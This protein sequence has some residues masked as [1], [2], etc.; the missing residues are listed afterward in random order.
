[1]RVGQQF[2]A[3]T[4]RAVSRALGANTSWMPLRCLSVRLQEGCSLLL[5][6]PVGGCAHP[7]PGNRAMCHHYMDA[8]ALSFLF[9]R[10]ACVGR[11][12]A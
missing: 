10:T 5:V 9:T 8:D 1:M 11:G 3:D 7:V 2:A 6:K 4:P 12:V